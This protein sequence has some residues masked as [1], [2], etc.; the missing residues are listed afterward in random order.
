MLSRLPAKKLVCTAP[1]L[2]L[3]VAMGSREAIFGHLFRGS[4]PTPPPDL[5]TYPGD[6]GGQF[7]YCTALTRDGRA[8]L[9]LMRESV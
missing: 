6:E 7:L 8:F 1:E 3:C 2:G 5:R 9:D 4:R